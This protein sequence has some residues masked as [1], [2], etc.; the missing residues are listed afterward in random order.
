MVTAIPN[1]VITIRNQQGENGNLPRQY[2]AGSP[3]IIVSGTTPM[4]DPYI[5]EKD[6]NYGNSYNN[7]LYIGLPNFLYVRGRNFGTDNVA[8]TWNLFWST[9]NILLLPYLWQA[10]QLATSDG[11][12][13]PAFDIPAGA[14]GASTNAF[15]WTP[16]DT[17]DHY[18]MIAIA[19][20]PGHPNPLQGVRNVS[21]L[22]EAMANNANIAQRNLQ[23]VRGNLPQVVSSAAYNQGDEEQKMDIVVI[24][25]NLPKGS[26][27]T[28]G[29]G[30]PL[31]GKTL[32]HGETNTKDNDFKYGWPDQLV[33]AQW[34]TMFSYT[35]TFG[36]DWSDIPDDAKPELTIRG[37]V[38]LDSEHRLYNHPAAR[39]AEPDIFTNEIRLDKAGNKVK[40]MT[41]GTVTTRCPDIVRK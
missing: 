14:I 5:L 6:G 1:G 41:A 23:L 35:M 8:G 19:N 37:E 4:D 29:S 16:A 31:N 3:D 15:T 10:N 32:Q 40:L 11:N 20:S 24:I 33:P 12:L 7:T 17:Q 39:F 13:S 25:K 22:A 38:V 28:V 34:S 36:S 18:C 9:P 2:S 30:T 26:S 21:S 27:Y